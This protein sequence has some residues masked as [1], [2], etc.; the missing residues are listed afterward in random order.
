MRGKPD[1]ALRAR[2]TK[3]RVEKRMSFDEISAATGVARGTLSSWL[4]QY[5]LTT[6]EREA[7]RKVQIEKAGIALRKDR[8][9]PSKWVQQVN[10]QSLTRAQKAKI[11]EAAVLFRLVLFGFN[12]YGPV[13]D[14]DRTDWLIETPLAR[15]LLRIQVKWCRTPVVGQPMV[16]LMC[17]D[18]AH[19]MRRYEECEFDAIVGYDLHTDIAYVFLPSEIASNKKTVAIAEKYAERWEKLV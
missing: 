14:G 10:V 3:L 7:R 4:S 9:Q 2:A 17:A 16:T 8:G 1:P 11:A 6:E 13:F 5:P 12:V 18:G 19:G 15:K